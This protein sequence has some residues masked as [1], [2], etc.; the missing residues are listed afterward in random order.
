[1]GARKLKA[2]LI[3]RISNIDDE[4]VLGKVKALLELQDFHLNLSEELLAELEQ[5][6]IS[7]KKGEVI[8]QERMDK[9]VQ[10]W[11]SEK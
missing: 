10:Q 7:V 5:A 9:N 4:I 2:D 1:M 11:L 3:D 6:R 8:S